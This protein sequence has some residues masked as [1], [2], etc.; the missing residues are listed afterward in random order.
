VASG[1]SRRK[2]AL[3]LGGVAAVGLGAVWVIVASGSSEGIVAGGPLACLDCHSGASMPADVGDM[4]TYGAADLQNHGEEP[5]V[6][7]H[8]EFVDIT[9]GLRILGPLVSRAGDR[10]GGGIGLIRE[11]PPPG[12]KGAL[13][14]LHGYR[15]LPFRSFADDVRILV[16]VSP[17]RTG[18]LSYRQLRLYYRVGSKRY[19]ATFDMGV[20]VCAPASVPS[21][22]CPTPISE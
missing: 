7:D 2:L 14:P 11:F 22:R 16:G 10:P 21:T 13:H 3:L 5:A 4:G 1:G 12:L 8:V 18:K 9:P 20:R 17:L 6:L 15:V 19:V